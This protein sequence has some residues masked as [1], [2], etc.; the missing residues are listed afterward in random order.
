MKRANKNYFQWSMEQVSALGKKGLIKYLNDHALK[1]AHVIK[2]TSSSR[3]GIVNLDLW[4][5]HVLDVKKLLRE[6]RVTYTEQSCHFQRYISSNSH[7]FSIPV[8]IGEKPPK[9]IAKKAS[10]THLRMLCMELKHSPLRRLLATC[11]NG[12]YRTCPCI[13]A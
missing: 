10:K 6:R 8:A 11:E 4:M 9:P 2:R 1:V 3:I 5:D 13:Y 12:R 7:F